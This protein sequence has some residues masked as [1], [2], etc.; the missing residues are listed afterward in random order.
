MEV[1][2]GDATANPYLIIAAVTAA[3]YL[4]IR[5]KA[6]PRRRLKDT[7]TT[8]PAPMLPQT[9]PAALDALE[10]D[11]ALAEVLGDYFI[12]SFLAYKRNEVERFERFVTDWE[13]REYAYHL[14]NDL[15][16]PA[17]V[18]RPGRRRW[19]RMFD[20]LRREAP[21]SWNPESGGNHGFWSVTRF[22]D[23]EQ[24][25]KSPRSSPP[26]VSSTSRSPPSSTWTC[27][28][29]CWKP[30]APATRRCA[31]CSCATSARDPAPL[32]RLPARAGPSPWIPRCGR[33]SSTSS[34][35]SPPTT[36]STCS[37]A[38]STSR[39]SHPAARLLGQRDRR[40]HRPGLCPRPH[41]QPGSREIQP[42]PVPLARLRRDL[43][44]RPQARRRTQGRQRRRPGQQARAADPRGRR[45]ADADRLRQLL[46]PAGR[47]RQRD[48]QAGDQPCHEGAHGPPGAAG[49]LARQSRQVPDRGRGAAAVR[50]AGVP[51][52]AHRD[53]RRRDGRPADQ[54]RATRS[55]C[56]SLR[57]T[58]T[59]RCS[60]TRTGWT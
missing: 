24:V 33:R 10:A 57:A 14:A 53:P 46:P 13:F 20:T 17:V 11:T 22:A 45:A 15:P 49:V 47:G 4:G 29:P 25:D 31:S 50:L 26:S 52:P 44:V 58:G 23:I 2:L 56:G 60:P 38:C 16:T 54:G 3:A 18:R 7:A 48:D 51:L 27:G 9:L 28:A 37:P 1:R 41:R 19:G 40:C 21:V 5:D 6:D 36:R 8:R 30:T 43:R 35:R 12:G 39:T 34:T 55:S 59:R 42:P 32:R